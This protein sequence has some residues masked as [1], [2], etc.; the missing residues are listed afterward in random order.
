MSGNNDFAAWLNQFP[1]VVALMLVAGGWILAYFARRWV[2]STVLWVNDR[3]TRW[4]TRSRPILSP[5]FGKALQQIVYW[6]IVAT[7]IILG[8]SHVGSGSFA[9]WI[10]RLWAL[11]SHLLIALAILATGH[12]LGSLA[13]SLLGGLSNR[14]NLAA[15]PRL[16]YVVIVGVSLIMALSHMGLNVTFITQIV[17]VVIGVFFA[18]LALA[19]SLGAR[20]LVANLA[21]QDEINR[22]KPGDRLVIEDVEGT[23]IELNRTGMVLSTTRGLVRVPASKFA[24]TAVLLVVA[25]T[26]DE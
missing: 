24:E 7:F 2:S 15:L 20:S 25:E 10:D 6:G 16:A 13:R 17:L 14:A 18:G 3:S 4:T 19:F 26:G 23:V 11:I 21:A 22:Y 1:E 8:L 5:T 12:I 9:G